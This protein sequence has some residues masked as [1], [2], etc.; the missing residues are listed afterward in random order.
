MDR[1]KPGV[2][3]KFIEAVKHLDPIDAEVCDYLYR[4]KVATILQGERNT[5]DIGLIDNIAHALGKRSDEIEM[6]VFHLEE[7]NFL[8]SFPSGS[9]STNSIFREFMRAVFPE[10]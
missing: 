9:W 10:R 2:R 7:L 4:E 3:Y 8:V 1:A 6:S 5:G